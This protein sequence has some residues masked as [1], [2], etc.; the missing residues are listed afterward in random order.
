MIMA[1]LVSNP[2]FNIWNISCITSQIFKLFQINAVS[3][4]GAVRFLI[5][6]QRG[7]DKVYKA[8]KFVKQFAE[9]L[10]QK[11]CHLRQFGWQLSVLINTVTLGLLVVLFLSTLRCKTLCEANKLLLHE[12]GR[13]ILMFWLLTR[14]SKMTD[15]EAQR[16]RFGKC[17]VDKPVLQRIT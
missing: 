17:S 2:Q 10:H 6:C 3:E 1:Y 11:C 14:D 9:F 15:S 4:F 7:C 13:S 12:V 8:D 5:V 16:W